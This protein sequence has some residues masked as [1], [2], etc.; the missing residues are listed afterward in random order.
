V[1]APRSLR[2]WTPYWTRNQYDQIPTLE[3]K[4]GPTLL[5]KLSQAVLLKRDF[6]QGSWTF[7]SFLNFLPN[8]PAGNL[9]HLVAFWD[10]GFD[11]NYPDYLPPHPALGS[12]ADLQNLVA[13]A[14]AAGHLVMPY[15]NPTWW[16]DASPTL[17]S[18]G[19][20]IVA[21]NRSGNLVYENYGVHGGYVVSPHSPDVIARQDQT[22]DEFTLTV[23][24]DLLFEDQVGARQAPEIDDN[25]AARSPTLYT[26]GLVE[27]AERSSQW[28]PIM[29]EGGFDRI[30]WYETGFC[31]SQT[32]GWQWWPDS[33]FDPFPMTQLWAHENMVF[34]PHNLA[35]NVMANNL[36]RMTYYI[37]LGY[38]LSYNLQEGDFDWLDV[39]DCF[40]KQF[41]ANLVGQSMTSFELL[42]T[43]GHTR[44][45]YAD[46]TTVTANLTAS[47][48]G[49]DDHVV[50]PDGF[51]AQ[52][53]GN[54]LAGVFTTLHGQ[55][56]SGS[57]PHYLA[58][59]HD[60]YRIAVYQPRGDDTNITLPRPADWTEQDRISLIG[61]TEAGARID[62]SIIVFADK[63]IYFHLEAITG[64]PVDHFEVIYCRLGDSDCDGDID[65][66][67]RLAF[68]DCFSGPGGVINPSPPRTVQECLDTF[69]FNG[70][71]DIDVDDFT[72][73]QQA[74]DGSL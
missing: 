27:V 1:S 20:G 72:A 55:L 5:E 39:L 16:D 41:V 14:R 25:P 62:R 24:C 59:N 31:N 33:T 36:S 12:L 52:Q 53:N 63:V 19:T 18:L 67:D 23:P 69:D 34:F 40:Q 56:L 57:S 42:S 49:V 6:F 32:I 70:D 60:P 11:E 61:V 10:N 7:N 35:G 2:R 66:D 37:A 21:V 43:T 13:T 47:S 54:V 9:L 28:L 65:D 26:Q 58:L 45:S 73:F 4:I 74:F 29:S 22:R 17:A 71:F 3:E 15:T 30:T 8:I 38:S 51:I 48:R 44:A 50:A 46:G 64:Q 68:E